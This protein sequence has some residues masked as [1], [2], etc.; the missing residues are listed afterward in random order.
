[1]FSVDENATVT[2]KNGE[3]HMING[4]NELWIDADNFIRWAI[5]GQDKFYYDETLD[6]IVFK[7]KIIG[8]EIYGSNIY[9][10]KFYDNDEKVYITIGGEKSSAMGDLTIYNNNGE[11]FKIEDQGTQMYLKALGHTFV[12]SSGSNTIMKNTW[13]Y[14]NSEVATKADL[15]DLESRLSK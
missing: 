13:K 12:I 6:A 4:N 10:G 11:R 14:G 2:I 8:S 5:N 1:M 15:A 3:I 9:G 7:G